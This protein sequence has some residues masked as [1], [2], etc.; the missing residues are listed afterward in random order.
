MMKKNFQHIL[1]GG[2]KYFSL[3]ALCF[4]LTTGQVWANFIV[5]EAYFE[6]KTGE[7]SFDQVREKPFTTYQGIL[8]KGFTPS[9]FWLRLK[10]NSSE[11]NLNDDQPIALRIRPPYVDEI[12]LYDTKILPNV[13]TTGD[14]Q[15]WSN[16]S[17]QSINHGFVLMPEAI[18]RYLWLRI[19]SS[20]SM[21]VGV[22]ALTLKSMLKAEQKQVYINSLDVVLMAFLMCWSIALL[23]SRPDKISISFV[24]LQVT[25]LCFS[26]AYF[27]V[28]RVHYSAEVSAPLA[29]QIY[30][31]L[32]I[33][34]PSAYISFYRNLL[35]EYKPP[36]WI[37]KIL[38]GIALYP[39]LGISLIEAEFTQLALHLNALLTLTALFFLILAI[40]FV[41]INNK[42]NSQEKLIS[43]WV[44]AISCWLFILSSLTIIL[45]GLGIIEASELSLYRFK[46][47][48]LLS[49]LIIG[50]T[51][52]LRTKRIE[53]KNIRTLLRA[54]ELAQFERKRR[55]EQ[56]N[57]FAMLTHEIRTPLTAMAYAA[58]T[59]MPQKELSNQIEIGVK[60]IDS[61]IEHC[62]QADRLEENSYAINRKPIELK[63]LIN[64]AIKKSYSYD[65]IV[66]LEIP[67]LIIE[68]DSTLAIIIL[69]NLIEN[70]LK[71][72]KPNSLVSL[73]A[74]VETQNNQTGVS[75]SITN[76]L[77]KFDLPDPK[78]LFDK[79]Y[80]SPTSYATTGSGLGLF[81]V[82]SIVNMLGGNV[83]YRSIKDE[84][85]FKIWLPL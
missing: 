21:I 66:T 15:D 55:E 69:N 13:L 50:T 36:K 38:F 76:I 42:N 31:S 19:K 71:Y 49:A 77:G 23:I 33:L 81:L 68:T 74:E 70:A 16:Q 3:A 40:F 18:P 80:R 48:S 75:I 30:S 78:R 45:P 9:V 59:A 25:S 79:Y 83:S 10:I 22:D 72:S 17:F 12:K 63:D 14:M 60:E 67:K 27:G 43:P 32:F 20:S 5:E 6:D 85:T 73:A 34:L 26:L 64:S 4:L 44:I 37:M 53:Q 11:L 54:K 52:Y 24:F 2:V 46:F 47:Q 62:S 7:L 56:N 57:F 29:N 51:V 41:L 82:K 61:I 65:R 1:T 84:V 8:S 39:I 58:Q 28:L 35:Q